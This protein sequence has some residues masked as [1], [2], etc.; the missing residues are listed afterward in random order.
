MEDPEHRQPGDVHWHA[1]IR[2]GE[3]C[4]DLADSRPVPAT[5]MRVFVRPDDVVGWIS[6]MTRRH[7]HRT[8]IRLFGSADW[9]AVGDADQLCLDEGA[10]L[11]WLSRGHSLRID[12]PRAHDR[13]HLW[14]EATTSLDCQEV[15]DV[16]R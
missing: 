6:E 10:N 4:G 16:S 8:P 12:F 1:Y 11:A 5:P 3:T 15:H 2:S 7:A 13:M 14:I 9:A